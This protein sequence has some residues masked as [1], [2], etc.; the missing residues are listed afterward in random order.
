MP[1]NRLVRLFQLGYPSVVLREEAPRPE[2][3]AVPQAYADVRDSHFIPLC[4]RFTGFLKEANTNPNML[5]NLVEFL[6]YCVMVCD[7]S[8]ADQLRELVKSCW[9]FLKQTGYL[10]NQLYCPELCHGFIAVLLGDIYA[11]LPITIVDVVPDHEI[12]PGGTGPEVRLSDFEMSLPIQDTV[13][14]STGL[15]LPAGVEGTV[16]CPESFNEVGIQIGAHSSTLLTEAGPWRRWPLVVFSY[17]MEQESAT[18]GSPF[19]G[20]VYI[21]PMIMEPQPPKDTLFLFK[22]FCRYPRYVHDQPEIWEQTRGIDVPWGEIDVGSTIFTLPSEEMRKVRDFVELKTIYDQF[23][24]R[25]SS[26]LSYVPDR[27]YRIVFDSDVV[28]VGEEDSGSRVE[29]PATFLIEDI[30]AIVL[31]LNEARPALYRAIRS[32][33]VLSIRVDC[34]DPA[35]EFALASVA[36]ALAFQDV[37]DDFDPFDPRFLPV[38]LLF[39]QFWEIEHV[40]PT[41]FS[42]TLVMFQSPDYMPMDSPDDMWVEFVRELCRSGHCNYTKLLEQAKP[43]PL[44]ISQSLQGLPLMSVKRV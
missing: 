42:K 12:F 24:Q 40:T 14:I 17:H 28:G 33:A 1:V 35:T 39:R 19:G 8:F 41:V 36:T 38:P 3:I 20:I 26:F 10:M 18:V 29:Y 6:R 13:W 11:K 27:S 15:W 31:D 44:N 5:D 23:T 30:S 9:A 32:L 2:Q 25:I 7:I 37:F 21:T 4:T 16:E 34:F 43:V 22:N